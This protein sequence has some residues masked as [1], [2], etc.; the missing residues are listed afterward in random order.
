[1]WTKTYRRSWGEPYLCDS[2]TTWDKQHECGEGGGGGEG[3]KKI[4]VEQPFETKNRFTM[5]PKAIVD[6]KLVKNLNS[7]ELTFLAVVRK[8]TVLHNNGNFGLRNI[9]RFDNLKE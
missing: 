4:A 9:K 8:H 3:S 1:M 6:K 2:L 7:T 5:I